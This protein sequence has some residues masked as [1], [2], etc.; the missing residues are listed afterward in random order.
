MARAFAR[1]FTAGWGDMDFNSHMR[2]TAYLDLSATTRM[3]YF[4]E[5]GFSMREF[6]RL[7][8]GPVIARDELAYFKEIRLLEEFTV[9]VALAG[10]SEDGMRFRFRNTFLREDG[11]AAA[12][13]TSTG[14]WLS[15][16]LR[17]L[18]P[19]PEALNEVMRA[20]ERTGDFE[21]LKAGSAGR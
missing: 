3:M 11:N 19:P 20:L 13:V 14:G 1:R 6:E 7:R 5:H 16:E 9:T 18:A 2:N 4:Q 17:R 12:V 8:F 10:L 15:L 21:E